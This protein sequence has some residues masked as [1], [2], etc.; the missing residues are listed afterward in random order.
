MKI[1]KHVTVGGLTWAVI[2]RNERS[3]THAGRYFFAARC[4][5]KRPWHIHEHDCDI[6]KTGAAKP[7]LIFTYDYETAELSASVR[8]ICGEIPEIRLCQACYMPYRG[9]HTQCPYCLAASIERHPSMT[10]EEWRAATKAMHG[11]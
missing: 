6:V 2:S 10:L 8:E 4:N 9:E 1:N 5:P 3:V 11:H 7:L